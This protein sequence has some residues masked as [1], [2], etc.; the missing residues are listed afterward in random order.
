MNVRL[1]VF[2]WTPKH[3]LAN[4][5]DQWMNVGDWVLVGNFLPLRR[6]DS[7][8]EAIDYAVSLKTFIDVNFKK[9]NREEK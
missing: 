7:W 3:Y 1:T 5:E 6:F 9:P 2:K 8:E 4:T